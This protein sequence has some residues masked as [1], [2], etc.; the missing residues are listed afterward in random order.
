M[1]AS[2]RRVARVTSVFLPAARSIARLVAAA[3]LA[4]AVVG[5]ATA[6]ATTGA[7][8]DAPASAT[9]ATRS[10]AIAD[11]RYEV[12]YDDIAAR[13]RA[14][15]VVM[16]F[17]VAGTEPVLLSLPAW[18]PG[19]YEIT[20]FAKFVEDFAASGDGRPLDWDKVDQ[21]T[22]RVPPA[23]AREVEVRFVYRGSDFDNAKT[24]LQSDFAF[25]NGTNV[26]LYPEGR[27]LEFASTVVIRTAPAW[28]VATGMPAAAAS[29]A[30]PGAGTSAVAGASAFAAASYHDLVDYPV[31]VGR[32]DWDSV[33]VEDGWSRVASYP[34]G[35]L[36]GSARAE[37]H[38]Q[39]AKMIPEQARVFGG[40]VPWGRDYTTL[41]VFSS[42]IEG[43]SALE[44]ANSH[45]GIYQPEI[46]GN[47]L[48]PSITA[49]EIFH[50]WNVKRLRPAELVPYR[51]DAPQPTPLLWM[52]E[53]ITDYYADLTLVRA[54]IVPEPMF[55][56]LVAGKIDEVA[57]V[58]AVALEDASLSTWIAPVDGTATI[59]YAKGSLAGFLL[60]ILIRDGSDN[61]RGLDDV[62]RE[63]YGASE[64][65]GVRGFT[66]AQFWAA[67]SRAAGGRSFAE[68]HERYIDGRAPYPWAEVL[69]LA[70]LRLRADTTRTPVLGLSTQP[71]SVGVL[72]G[73]LEPDG[74]AERAGVRPGDYLVS[75][76]DIPVS[77]NLFGVRFRQRYGTQAGKPLAIVVRRDGRQQ[78]LMGSVALRED[79]RHGIIV[80]PSASAKAVR[81]RRGILK[82]TTD[83]G[84]PATK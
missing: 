75:V 10:A 6:P 22:W 34:R 29:A 45:L 5:C 60:D 58:P 32:I 39:V 41:L 76:G 38:S 68:F 42:E 31:F 54:G 82:G 33:R 36:A 67:A 71:D 66:D 4:G 50:A 46:I 20:D 25:F 28:K 18:T 2:F 70:G 44:H 16:R 55:N 74:V 56:G 40:D 8:A 65:T 19:A 17:T 73:E 7:R 64:N 77:D 23:G 78:T 27:S 15:G 13:R 1:A 9:V 35:S 49:H 26:F 61:R 3:S 79:A 53:G 72:V 51:Y 63:L 80:D 62:M 12:T 24:W 14:L 69:P 43:G 30:A 21:D 83:A 48:L 81:I 59:Y 47:P 84:A 11:V 57:A 37:F 52:S